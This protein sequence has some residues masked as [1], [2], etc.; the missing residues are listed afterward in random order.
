MLD[1]PNPFA[2]I[3]LPQGAQAESGAIWVPGR[4]TRHPAPLSE[5]NSAVDGFANRRPSGGV[6][7]SETRTA[8][9]Q[10]K[11]VVELGPLTVK[12]PDGGNVKQA[13]GPVTTPS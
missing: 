7:P 9:V 4:V 3:A 10:V 1:F 13:I 5:T 2:A 8:G 6:S 12:V 11:T